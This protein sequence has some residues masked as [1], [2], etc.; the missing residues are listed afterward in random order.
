MAEIPVTKKSS[1][2]WLWILLVLL[3]LALLAWYVFADND[4]DTA[5]Y[6]ADD[7][8][9]AATVA[10]VDET[11]VAQT[12]QTAALVVGE[13]VKLNGVKVS[14]LAGDMAFYIEM[15][16]QRVPVFFD[17]VPTPGTAIEGKYDINAGSVLNL[18]GE[19]RSATD[20]LPADADPSILGDSQNYIFA[21]SIEM[22]R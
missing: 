12:E 2:A 3:I 15:N 7:T 21:K 22:V 14:S 10:G 1:L 13:T 17:Q 4:D 20:T 6:V 8:V 5:G 18:E 9:A 19:V 16:G 11:A